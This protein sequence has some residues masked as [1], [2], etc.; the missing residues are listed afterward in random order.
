[1]TNTYHIRP[2]TDSDLD[3]VANIARQAWGRIHQSYRQ[4]IGDEMH[5][6]LCADWEA[7]K[8]GQVR[9]HWQQHPDWF[10]VVECA[11]T[12]EVVGFITFRVDAAKSMGTIGNNAVAPEA[13]GNGIGTMMYNYVLDL[14]RKHGLKYACVTTGLDEGHASARRAYEKVGFDIARPDVTYYKYLNK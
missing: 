10:R 7:E 11:E 4:I 13:Q 3:R 6:D 1:M 2:A 14:F 5:R 8:E 9:R 12:R